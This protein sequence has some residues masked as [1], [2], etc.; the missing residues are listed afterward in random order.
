M[1]LVTGA[2]GFVGINLVQALLAL[3]E[4][5]LALDLEEF[6]PELV[7]SEDEAK[8]IEFRAVDIR[9]RDAVSQVFRE[10]R[11]STA[12]HAAA[13]TVPYEEDEAKARL[14]TE[15]NAV[16]TLNVL[17]AARDGGV[18]RF[19]YVSSSGV[20]GSYGHGVVPVH[21]TVPYAPMGLY[22]ASK[23]YSELMCRRFNEMG[24]FRVVVSRIG[25]PYGPWERPTRTR[26]A[27]SPL[28]R[29]MD[30]AMNGQ[31]ALI[32]G[33]DSVRDWT[34]VRDIARGVALLATIEST[35]LRHL[36]YNVSTGENVSAGVVAEAIAKAVPTFRYRF[37]DN[38]QEANVNMHLPN[39]RG[40]LNI[41][42]I[43]VDCGFKPVFD[44]WQGMADYARWYTEYKTG[45]VN[46]GVRTVEWE[47]QA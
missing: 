13:V 36:V 39:P 43:K 1:I 31:E 2:T 8:R 34:H 22:V 41:T 7:F 26:Q 46:P 29:L 10:Y 17:E 15:V 14:V 21:E 27:M 11:I 38:P 23:I 12:V 19:V 16:G 47:G 24:H 18:T 6:P 3:G 45:R 37:V 32:Y 4:E 25:S 44:I 40:P 5:V 20:Y 30:M 42:R 28:Q 33:Y 35:R 9:D